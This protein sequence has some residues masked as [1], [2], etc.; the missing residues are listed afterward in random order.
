MVIRNAA[1]CMKEDRGR[2][3]GKEAMSS[4]MVVIVRV[5]NLV[6]DGELRKILHNLG[7]LQSVLINYN[8]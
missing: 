6:Q 1:V 8:G 3:S 4:I 7:S 2:K 5:Q